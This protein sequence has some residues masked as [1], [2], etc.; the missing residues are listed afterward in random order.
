MTITIV[1]EPSLLI[2]TI[3]SVRFNT[4][5]KSWRLLEKYIMKYVMNSQQ[6]DHN[7]MIIV[8]VVVLTIKKSWKR[9]D[10]LIDWLD[11]V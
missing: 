4:Q 8:Y 11:R 3:Y 7:E 1:I 10:W 5:E 9:I 6:Q 2:I